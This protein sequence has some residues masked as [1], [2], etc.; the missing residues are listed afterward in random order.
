MRRG[1]RCAGFACV[2]AACVAPSSEPAAPRVALGGDS[3][4]V[5][6][7]ERVSYDTGIPA[8][9]LATLSYVETRFE[10]ISPETMHTHGIETYGILG[11]PRADLEAGARLAGVT[12]EAARTDAIASLRA[13]AALLRAN[14]PDAVSVDD[15][16]LTLAP[17]LRSEVS[18]ILARGL[19][20]RDAAGRSIVVAARGGK[21]EAF[22]TTTQALGYTGAEWVPASTAN[23]AVGNRTSITN[24]VIHT[25]QGSYSGTLSWFKNPDAGVSAHY[26]VR[27]SDGHIAQMVDEKNVAWH[28]KCFNSTTIGIEHEGFVEKPAQWYTEAMYSESAKLTSYLADKYNIEKALGPIVG[29]GDAPDCSTHTDPGPGW[30]W[31]HYIDLVKVGG[32]GSFAAAD[33]Q[34]IVP[35]TV[36]SGERVTVT[37][38]VTNRGTS[39][40]DL[41]ITRL[42]TALPQD[43]ESALFVDGDW[44]SPNRAAAVD[45]VVRAGETGTF[46]FDIIAPQVK[47]PTVI[48]EAFQLV[49]EG[50][51]WFG[52]EI[53]VTTQVTPD[54]SSGGCSTTN[55]SS[56]A[57][58]L[59]LGALLLR[60]RRRR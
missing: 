58:L 24:V 40:W 13:G 12:D 17:P 6:A 23:Y 15:F 38:Q 7:F 21:R 1:I 39:A 54:G 50:V 34:V 19:D 29:H 3:P 35:P 14:A 55:G 48:D 4:L 57:F 5:A 60:R 32:P 20:G 42:G 47:E 49:E 18:A 53:H 16:L 36:M 37:V 44:I 41:D 22:G 27:S 2:L 46:T 59:A 51:I 31:A 33:V 28:D 30:D 9:L 8:E 43:R 25:T 56:G 10:H 26:V 45:T 52:P 11:L